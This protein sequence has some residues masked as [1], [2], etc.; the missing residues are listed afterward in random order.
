MSVKI[1][2]SADTSQVNRR[3]RAM[4]KRLTNFRPVFRWAFKELQALHRTNFELE[5]ALDGRPWAPLDPQY[6]SWKLENYGAKGILVRT[7]DLRDSLV[8][9]NA[10][11]AVREIRRQSATFGTEI[12]YAKFH[13]R[14]TTKMPRRSPILDN[15]FLTEVMSQKIA[16]YIV[17]GDNVLQKANSFRRRSF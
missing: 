8:F 7:G 2:V 11:G 10:R 6:A 14:G 3:Y 5:G 12:E 13:E 15:R 16:N 1:R 17:E 9:D 4:T